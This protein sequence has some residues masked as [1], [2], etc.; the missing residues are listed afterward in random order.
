MVVKGASAEAEVVLHQTD[1]ATRMRPACEGLRQI[2]LWGRIQAQ[3]VRSG[4]P[5]AYRDRSP[6]VEWAFLFSGQFVGP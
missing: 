5:G 6:V 1:S 3:A 4:P 2:V